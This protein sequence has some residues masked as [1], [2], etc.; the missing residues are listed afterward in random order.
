MYVV[1]RRD[2]ADVIIRFSTF[3]LANMRYSYIKDVW[4]LIKPVRPELSRRAGAINSQSVWFMNKE[5]ESSGSGLD[6][7]KKSELIE[8]ARARCLAAAQE[9]YEDAG[10]RGLC[11]EGRW[12]CAQDA[13]RS[14]KLDPSDE[15]FR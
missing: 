13:I 3:I 10:V 1:K 7:K 9:A 2:Y 12:E 11:P 15:G 5:K 8:S 4:V 14:V 6:I